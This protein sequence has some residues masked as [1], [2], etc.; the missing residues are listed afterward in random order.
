MNLANMSAHIQNVIP[1][2]EIRIN[3]FNS[4][5]V[6]IK[7]ANLLQHVNFGETEKMTCIVKCK[8]V[9]RSFTEMLRSERCKNM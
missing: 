8:F 4:S 9:G 2:S 7:M 3:I 1:F 5:D 6:N